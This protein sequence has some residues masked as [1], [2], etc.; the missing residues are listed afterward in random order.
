MSFDNVVIIC[1]V[2]AVIPLALHAITS[3][4]AAALV[5]AGPVSVLVYPILALHLLSGDSVE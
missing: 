5:A 4:D 1:A 2:A 3:D